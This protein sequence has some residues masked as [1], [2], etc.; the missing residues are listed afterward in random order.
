MTFGQAKNEI[1]IY[2]I[3]N[4]FADEKEFKKFLLAKHDYWELTQFVM[5]DKKLGATWIKSVMEEEARAMILKQ[6]LLEKHCD[7]KLLNDFEQ[8]IRDEVRRG[9]EN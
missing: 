5:M 9:D 2:K 6:M 4:E 8:A 3:N 7:P 1:I